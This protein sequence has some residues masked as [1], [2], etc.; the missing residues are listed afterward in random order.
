[1]FE[2]HLKSAIEQD[3]QLRALDIVLSAYDAY[4]ERSLSRDRLHKIQQMYDDWEASW[5]D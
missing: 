5:K 1:M 3:N 4:T 2:R